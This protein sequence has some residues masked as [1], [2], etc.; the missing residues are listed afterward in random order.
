M[1]LS[2]PTLIAIFILTLTP[3]FAHADW[4]FTP[5]AGQTFKGDSIDNKLNYGVGIG[6]MGAGI[7][8]VEFDASSTPEFFGPSEDFGDN[9]VTTVMVNLIAGAPAGG[10]TGLGFRPYATAGVGLL[11]S[12]ADG[13]QGLFSDIR[14][15]DFGVNVGGG[16]MGFFSD[17]IGVRGDVRYFRSLDDINSDF[18]IG[19][20]LGNFDFWR[21]GAGAVIRW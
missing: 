5:F 8:G 9:N 3:S 18:S 1:R 4:I 16:V 12:R 17:H 20:P 13:I 2:K 10:Q 21:W 14:S 11:R 15:N 6:F 19:D 7:F